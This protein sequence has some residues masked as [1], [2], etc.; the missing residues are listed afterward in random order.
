MPK[1]MERAL[2]READ[3]KHLEGEH[4][5]AFIYGTMRKSGWKPKS[6]VHIPGGSMHELVVLDSNVGTAHGGAVSQPNPKDRNCK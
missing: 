1:A 3:K 4:R 5:N 6:E 2:A